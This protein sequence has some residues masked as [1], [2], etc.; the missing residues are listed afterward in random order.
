[1]SELDKTIEELEQEVVAELDEANGLQEK[2]PDSTG[3]KA[4]PMPKM[5][6]GEEPEDVGGP[7][8]T[9]DANQAGKPDAAKKVKK[10]TSD[11]SKSAVASEP[12]DKIKEDAD[13]EVKAEEDDVDETYETY[14]K[15]MMK[16]SKEDLHAMYA[17]E[18]DMGSKEKMVKAMYD[19]K[20]EGEHESKTHS[21][22]ED[23]EAL[24]QGE[25]FSDEFKSKAETIFEAA[26][27]SKIKSIEA[28][29][30]EENQKTL[31]EQKEDMVDKIDSY[32]NYVTEEWKKE[33]QLA[34]ERGLKGEIAE[35]F[36]SG[37]KQ[38]FEDHYIDVP[39]EKYNILEAQEKEIEDLKGKLNEKIEEDKSS[40]SRIG[41]LVRES[42]ISDATK[43]LAETEKEKFV[44]LTKDVEFS[45]E[46]SFK[47]KLDTLKESYFPSEQ[48]VEEVLSEETETE[49]SGPVDSDAMAAY[50]AAIQKTHKRAKNT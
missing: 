21:V 19:K 38:L 20:M 17:K 9:K 35:D 39:D 22:K 33:N 18:M 50:M 8:P 45:G 7:T 11:A 41:E 4:D 44:S 6:G 36:I 43:D 42:L 30:K 26:V 1:M 5:K 49:Q 32:L 24:L 34:I 40:K 13:K 23:V 48:K 25:D 28:Q 47:Q 31:E 29:L 10:D 46:E 12:A 15:E 3:G 16:H 37:L 2:S 14:K 27:S